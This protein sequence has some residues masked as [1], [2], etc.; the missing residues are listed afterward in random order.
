MLNLD[1]SKAL[2]LSVEERRKIEDVDNDWNKLKSLKHKLSEKT[3]ETQEMRCAYCECILG[4]YARTRP[5]L[6]HFVV[7]SLH[8]EFTFEPLNIFS[9]CHNCNE[10]L[11]GDEDVLC[12]E[13]TNYEDCEF[14]IVH[15]YLDDVDEHI[16]YILPKIVVNKKRSTSKGLK[17][18]KMFRLSGKIAVYYALRNK[19]EHSFFIK[20]GEIA[21]LAQ[22]S[23]T[24]K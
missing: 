6:D 22:E 2:S 18:I 20:K 12:R 17:T 1:K 9:S 4:E 23:A 24:Y 11:K 13:N 7:K 10:V 5:E 19:F 3:L 15:P 14:S 16:K 8:K 21:K